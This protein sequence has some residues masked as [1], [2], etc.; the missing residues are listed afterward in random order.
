LPNK[1]RA[2]T[3]SA[4][5]EHCLLRAAT[6]N[7]F[8]R[9][10]FAPRSITVRSSIILLL[11]LYISN[12]LTMFAGA[13]EWIPVNDTHSNQILTDFLQLLTGIQQADGMEQQFAGLWKRFLLNYFNDL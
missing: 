6:V 2:D 7:P 13:S 3:Y 1:S 10:R 4:L 9:H 8:G 12:P 11:Q 5:A